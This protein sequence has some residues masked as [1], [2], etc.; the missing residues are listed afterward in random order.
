M[1]A[2]TTPC[3]EPAGV[4]ASTQSDTGSLSGLASGPLQKGS[5]RRGGLEGE[6]GDVNAEHLC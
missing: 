2:L 4:F 5:H 1:C 3:M 6:K